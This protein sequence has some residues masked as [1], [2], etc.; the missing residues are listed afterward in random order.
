M[1]EGGLVC[2]V[3]GGLLSRAFTSAAEVSQGWGAVSGIARGTQRIPPAP[4]LQKDNNSTIRK[5]EH[6]QKDSRIPA[7]NY[8]EKLS[9]KHSPP[10]T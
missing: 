2:F 4:T 1:A 10:K 9:V 8:F 3:A 5:N 7:S 6:F